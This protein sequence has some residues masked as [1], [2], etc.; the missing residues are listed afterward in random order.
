MDDRSE[1]VSMRTDQ[2]TDDTARTREIRAEIE[3]T[4]E[5][6]SETVDAIQE[7]LRPSN[8]VSNAA[9]ATTERVKD[10][11]YNAA[12]TA[13]E[14]WEASGGTGLV[15]RIKEHPVPAVM[16]G[17]GIAWL[18]F[19]NG[20]SRRDRWESYRSDR[21]VP[22]RYRSDRYRAE[23]YRAEYET[24]PQRQTERGIMDSVSESVSDVGERS[25][26][27]V[28][29]SRNKLEL[30][31]RD[32]PLAV[33]AA[34]A[35]LG[36]TLGMVVPETE[37]E[38]ELMGEAKETAVEKAQQAATGAASRVKEAAADAVTKAVVGD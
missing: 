24:S 11:A 9:T 14:W 8:I 23:R 20:G 27:M 31:I 3:Q 16:A 30:M 34:A 1:S 36:A 13:G 35:V 26:R 33:G 4:R 10:M 38:N 12:D 22:D 5:D 29:R 37:Q 21:Y 18:A 15:D 32:Y 28:R 7:K 19:A 6:L 2:Q 17:I 25:S